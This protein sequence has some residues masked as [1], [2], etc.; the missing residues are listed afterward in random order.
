MT[1]RKYA[2]QRLTAAALALAVCAGCAGASVRS[3]DYAADR[4]LPRPP[5]LLLYPFAVNA[6][7]VV[8]DSLGPEFVTGTASTSKR[9]QVG[10]HVA[11]T[12]ADQLVRKLRARGI[13]AQRAS[14]STQPPL[15]AL[16]VKGQFVT[17]DEGD[18]T[19]RMVIGLGAGAEQLRVR[20]QVYQVT[21]SGLRQV[22]TGEAQA[23]GDQMPGMAIPV[24]AGAIAGRA[25]S[26]AVISGGMNVVQEVKGGLESAAENLAEQVAARAE[27]FYRRQGWL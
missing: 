27:E 10:R 20:A 12:L 9:L 14:A 22:R 19:K 23:H 15:H 11:N 2:S 6:Q 21:E 25:A 3:R 24:G 5:V 7:D 18:R 17:I 16:V 13:Q 26:A 1:K 8:V 4:S